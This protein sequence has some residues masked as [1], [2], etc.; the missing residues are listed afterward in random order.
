MGQAVV[1]TTDLIACTSTYRWYSVRL[2]DDHIR[3][4]TDLGSEKNAAKDARDL[5]HEPFVTMPYEAITDLFI[6]GVRGSVTISD[7]TTT[8]SLQ[9]WGQSARQIQLDRELPAEGSALS[10]WVQKKSKRTVAAYRIAD[11]I[12]E[13][14]G[15]EQV[16]AMDDPIERFERLGTGPVIAARAASASPLPPKKASRFWNVGLIARSVLVLLLALLVAKLLPDGNK[17]NLL[18]LVTACQALALLPAALT[19]LTVKGDQISIRNGLRKTQLDAHQIQSFTIERH[20]SAL[21]TTNQT[22]AD[23]VV[24]RLADGR[25]IPAF[26]TASLRHGKAQRVSDAI[27]TFTAANNIENSV[28]AE[29]FEAP[30]GRRNRTV[31]RPGQIE[32][33]ACRP[34]YTRS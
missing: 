30:F 3:I 15:L 7:A 1:S 4:S 19:R 11:Q 26:A 32:R 6:N 31:L 9:G 22:G 8:I 13:R 23:I 25:S 17:A 33:L 16:S 34:G 2:C 12:V 27:D 29:H 24:I 18:R 10:Q 21:F 28:V 5:L 14:S 20:T